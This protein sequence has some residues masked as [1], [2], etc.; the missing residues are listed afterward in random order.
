MA[1]SLASELFL[2]GCPLR[3][4]SDTL[5]LAAHHQQ[6]L[7]TLYKAR[8]F[9]SSHLGPGEI[10]LSPDVR[11]D[12]MIAV[13]RGR[14][15]D[16]GKSGGDELQHRHLK[17]TLVINT[18]HNCDGGAEKLLRGEIKVYLNVTV[19]ARTQK[20]MSTSKRR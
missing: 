2:P 15:R 5:I 3:I 11:L 18:R 16:P 20:D 14:H 10:L 7:G 19:F 12:Q 8:A 17:Q 6:S 9:P 13:D 4:G 1:P